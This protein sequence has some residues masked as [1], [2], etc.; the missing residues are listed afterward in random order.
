MIP[1]LFSR[2]AVLLGMHTT[3]LIARTFLSIYVAMLEG[4]MVKYIV[5]KDVDSFARN[6][7]RWIAV[8]VPAT[9]TNS[10]IR[11]LERH[12]ALAFRTRLTRHAH[13]L[14]LKGQTYYRVSNLDSRLVNAD[15]CLTDDI[16]AF[17]SSVAH[18][19][20]HVSKPILD[21]VMIT[22]QLY[23]VSIIHIRRGKNIKYIICW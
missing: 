12:L 21:V 2:E 19:Y 13:S 18:L 7:L 23:R 3:A 17:A 9:F 4:S 22:F 16:E 10:A 6:M 11:Y 14:Y 15:H 5:R 20:S 8:A 1:R